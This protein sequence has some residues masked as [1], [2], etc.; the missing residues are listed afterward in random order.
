M[1]KLTNARIYIW[2]WIG[3][4][5]HWWTYHFKFSKENSEIKHH[6]AP[7][8]V[9]L[10]KILFRDQEVESMI[11]KF[12]IPSP[13]QIINTLLHSATK[14]P[15]SISKKYHSAQLDLQWWSDLAVAGGGGG[16]SQRDSGWQI[17]VFCL[18]LLCWPSWAIERGY[19][20]STSSWCPLNLWAPAS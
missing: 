3:N 20:A 1:W 5:H 13:P 6:L 2:P 10:T 15:S 4:S 18:C 19:G 11:F 16:V 17:L 14:L 9:Q 8:Q 12:H 7:K